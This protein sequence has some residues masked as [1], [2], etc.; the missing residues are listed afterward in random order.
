MSNR[1]PW[2]TK[3]VQFL[4]D[5]ISKMTYKEIGMKIGRSKQSVACKVNREGFTKGK[6]NNRW[7]EKEKEFLI[8]HAATMSRIEIA[9]YLNKSEQSV[10]N[11]IWYLRQSGIKVPEKLKTRNTKYGEKKCPNCEEERLIGE[12]ST[13]DSKNNT[14]AM[15]YYCNTCFTE[16][17]K[18]GEI[19]PP[20]EEKIS[21]KK[22]TYEM[23]DMGIWDLTELSERTGL[24]KST[25]CEYRKRYKKEKGAI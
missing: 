21:G 11:Q 18:N 15:A 5:N 16:F 4:K 20:L 24:R 7:T 23:L 13:W 14:T 22:K 3:E 1:K 17:F 8:K 19:L 25:V 12:V 9:E 6:K 10:F 2:T